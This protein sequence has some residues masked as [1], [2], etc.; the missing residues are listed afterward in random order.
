MEISIESVFMF[1]CTLLVMLMTPA[2]ALFYGGLVK[3]K[4]VLSTTMHSYASIGV[5]SIQWIMIGFSLAFGSSVYGL[6]GGIDFFGL[7]NVGFAANGDY[8]SAIPFS[9]FMLFQM[10]FAILTPAI[11]SGAF[12]ERMK[13]NSF[14][15]FILLWTT[16]V[17]DP[18]AHWV[19][20]VGGWLRELGALDFAGGTVVHIASGVSGLVVALVLGKRVQSKDNVPHHVP[21]TIFGAGLLWFGWFGFNVGSAL[22]FDSIAMNAF[23]TTMVAATAASLSWMIVDWMTHKKPTALGAANGI[24]AGLVAITPACGFV[25][26]PS[27]LLIGFLSGIIC[28]YAVGALK[29]KLKY[30]DALDAFGLHGF[31]GIWGAVATGLFATTDVNPNG[32]DGLFFGGGF[33]LVIDQCIAVGATIAFCAI[34][35]YI[36]V[37]FVNKVL[38]MRVC[39]KDEEVGLD[40]SLHGERAYH[41]HQ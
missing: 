36:I 5:V 32:R 17:Y 40:L 38:P 28:N 20:G 25:N 23:V 37:L 31:G 14:L 26:T 34:A 29:E 27:A 4:N 15:L 9:L 12:A 19:W 21:L 39:E 7:K 3:S 16:F 10:M 35:T 6:F 30:D 18:L 22:T 33:D 24:V 1:V 8:S 2:L 13:F 41:Q 11:M